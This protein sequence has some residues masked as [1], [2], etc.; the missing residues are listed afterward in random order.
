MPGY[1][2]VKVSKGWMFVALQGFLGGERLRF[3]LKR[4]G[5]VIS[6]LGHYKYSLRNRR[7]F[8]IPL[9]VSLD[10]GPLGPQEAHSSARSETGS[11]WKNLQIS[12]WNVSTE[13]CS[14]FSRR[15]L[16]VHGRNELM[17]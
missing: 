15:R 4:T 8:E 14:R 1:I 16:T 5:H 12:H 10:A 13:E 17:A 11:H 9:S 3:A 6:R 2:N 7:I